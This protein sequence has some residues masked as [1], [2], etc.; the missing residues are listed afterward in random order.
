MSCLTWPHPNLTYPYSTRTPLVLGVS[1]VWSLG[2][3]SWGTCVASLVS[4]P[5]GEFIRSSSLAA[6]G[7]VPGRSSSLAFYMVLAGPCGP[8]QIKCHDR[9][10]ENASRKNPNCATQGQTGTIP[11]LYVLYVVFYYF[12]SRPRVSGLA[13]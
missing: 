8:I 9:T 10:R 2:L 6:K 13:P 12:S 4:R 3:E 7:V 11:S 5:I 1:K